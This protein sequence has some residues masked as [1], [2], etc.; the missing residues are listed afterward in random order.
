MNEYHDILKELLDEGL[1]CNPLSDNGLQYLTIRMSMEHPT[2]PVQWH[3]FTLT[4]K[5]CDFLRKHQDQP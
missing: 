1:I 5:G 3:K 2:L 4:Q